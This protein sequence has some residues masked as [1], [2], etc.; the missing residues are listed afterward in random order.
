M[1]NQT[2]TEQP[3][4]LYCLSRDCTTVGAFALYEL[5]STEAD[6]AWEEIGESIATNMSQDW[7]LTKA[8]VRYLKQLLEKFE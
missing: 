3:E 7:L 8:E 6:H 1:E 5:E 4:K 2:T